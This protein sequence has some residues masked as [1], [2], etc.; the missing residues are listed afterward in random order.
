MKEYLKVSISPLAEEQSEILIAFL[1]DLGYYAFEQEEGTLN[2][3][4]EKEEFDEEVLSM[5]LPP[6]SEFRTVAI[7]E[8]NWN[9]EWEKNFDP[10]VVGDFVA[11][12]ANFHNPDAEV[13]H[14]II[15]TPKMS[16]GT[17]HHATTFM[18]IELMQTLDFSE[19]SVLDFGTGTGVLAI[20]SEKLGAGYVLAIDND[21]WSIRNAGE[22]FQENHCSVIEIVKAEEIVSEKTFDIILAN[23]NFNVLIVNS[24]VLADKIK[25]SGHLVLSGFLPEDQLPMEKEFISQG[26]EL[27]DIRKRNNWMALAMQKK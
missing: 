26:F 2:A 6:A 10:V 11:V 19:K 18:M 12:R 9:T 17:G 20:L 13:K 21:D 23:I 3:F 4:I 5:H 25:P 1:S 7:P 16:F 22:N 15:V 27:R 24:G 8:R 14:E